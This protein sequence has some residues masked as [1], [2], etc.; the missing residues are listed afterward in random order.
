VTVSYRLTAR[1]RADIDGIGQWIASGGSRARAISF[2]AELEARCARLVEFPE[3]ARFW[4][5]Y[6]AGI[7]AVPFGRFLIL[8]RWRPESAMVLVVRVVGA[9]QLARPM[10]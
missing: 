7:R 3:A 10:S 6:G 8:Y 9:V 5:E 4:P 1:A 2:T